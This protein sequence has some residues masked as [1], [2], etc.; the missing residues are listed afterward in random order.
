MNDENFQKELLRRLD[1]LLRLS[2][3]SNLK[4]SS[5]TDKII[6]LDNLGFAPKDIADL[7]NT[8]GN[9]VN[10]ILSNSRRK[11]KKKEDTNTQLTT[12]ENL[13][14]GANGN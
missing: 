9:Y 1:A 4:E 13:A 14:E 8:T 7:L 12:T 3:A 6:F 11:N 2:V 5:Q 10:V